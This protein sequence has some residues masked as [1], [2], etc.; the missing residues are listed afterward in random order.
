MTSRAKY[1]LCRG[2]K[3]GLFRQEDVGNKNL[4]IPIDHREPRALN[5]DHDAVATLELLIVRGKKDLVLLNR[6]CLKRF[7]FFKAFQIPRAKHVSRD[8][9][10]VS[11]HRFIRFVLFRINVNHLDDP[12]AVSSRCRRK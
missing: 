2:L 3:V 12:I 6:I 5:L 10:L 11:T 9:E 4:R 1:L 7:G 8:H